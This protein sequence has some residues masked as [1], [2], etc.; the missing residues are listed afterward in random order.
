MS[1]LDI[2]T[3][4]LLIAS[5]Q[6]EQPTISINVDGEEMILSGDDARHFAFGFLVGRKA[7]INKIDINISQQQY[8]SGDN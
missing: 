8:E 7:E 6:I 1:K 4:M 2:K 5:K 3:T